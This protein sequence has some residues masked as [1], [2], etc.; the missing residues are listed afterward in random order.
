[1]R[2]AVLGAL[3]GAGLVLAAA[4]A[5]DQPHA[6]LAQR[7]A[8]QG[9][10]DSGGE[11][12]V[13]PGPT[14]EQGQ[15]LTVI[16]PKRQVLSVYHIHQATGKIALRSVRNIQWDLQLTYLDNEGLLPREIQSLL[17]AR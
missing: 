4:G 14:G 10:A 12:I 5:L 7:L 16:D 8:T 2:A 6:V 11:L 3:A 17:E 9:Q 13:V 1:M 15:L